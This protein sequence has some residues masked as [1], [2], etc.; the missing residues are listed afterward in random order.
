MGA[1]G[2]V[3]RFLRVIVART[4]P[5]RS[6]YALQ[7]LTI[8]CVHTPTRS[9]MTASV[10]TGPSRS[11]L[12][13][14]RASRI[15]AR[16]TSCAGCDPVRVSPVSSCRSGALSVTGRDFVLAMTASFLAGGRGRT[17]PSASYPHSPQISD[18]G[19][20]G[21]RKLA[22]VRPSEVQGWATDRSRVLAPTTVRQAV[23][24]LRS[25]YGSAGR[26][27]AVGPSPV[28]RIQLPRYERERIVPLSVE[29]VAALV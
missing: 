4:F 17:P 25:G 2:G 27:R 19:Q 24:L 20:L 16:R 28:V 13:S 21:G 1:T 6:A 7:I 5:P 11:G 8:V 3:S 22:D 18:D 23:G 26:D 15:L 12:F 14:S 29:Q 9:A 10:G